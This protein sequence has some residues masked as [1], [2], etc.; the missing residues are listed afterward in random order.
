M[1]VSGKCG[2]AMTSEAK[3]AANRRNAQRSTGPRAALAKA[4]IRRNA[5]RHGLAALVVSDPAVAAEV[6]RIAAAIFG[7]HADRLER[8]Q[9]LIVAEAQVTLKRVRRARAQIMEQ[10]SLVPPTQHPDA[11]DSA[12][13]VDRTAPY[14]D[15][16]MGLERYERRALSRRKRAVRL[17]WLR[18]PEKINEGSA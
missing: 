17:A 11:R 5:L 9:A 4:R 10:M 16:L 13:M 7:E 1:I 14:L 15:Q 6:E 8:E 2:S 18:D 3:I 12:S